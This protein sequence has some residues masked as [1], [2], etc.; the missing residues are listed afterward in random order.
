MR[1]GLIALVNFVFV[2]FYL[3]VNLYHMHMIFGL[4]GGEKVD[5]VSYVYDAAS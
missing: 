2:Y 1:C 5:T 3:N 4:L